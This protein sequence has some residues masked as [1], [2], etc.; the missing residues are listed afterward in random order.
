MDLKIL[1]ANPKAIRQ[2]NFT[3]NFNSA[4]EVTIFFISEEAKETILDFSNN[5]EKGL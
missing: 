2:L 4:A 5:T 3:E 1:Y